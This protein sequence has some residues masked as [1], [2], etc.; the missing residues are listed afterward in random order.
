MDASCGLN[1][2]VSCRVSAVV[3]VVCCCWT[4]DVEA[5]WDDG[6]VITRAV[7]L[8]NHKKKQITKCTST[9]R[10]YTLALNLLYFL[11]RKNQLSLLEQSIII[12]RDIKMT[13]WSWS[14]YSIELV[15]LHR[16]AGWPGCTCILVAKANDF[17]F[18]QDKE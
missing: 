4:T 18:Q 17:P 15:R 3:N 8:F 10:S 2:W 5:T 16:L 6:M 12:F 1:D 7:C 14:A 9:K 11:N 13:T